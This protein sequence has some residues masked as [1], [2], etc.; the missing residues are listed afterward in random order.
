MKQ[1]PKT[2]KFLAVFLVFAFCLQILPQMVLRTCAEEVADAFATEQTVIETEAS[3]T[4]VLEPEEIVAR[5][6]DLKT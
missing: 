3:E 6:T 5:R 4:V 2:L 1:V